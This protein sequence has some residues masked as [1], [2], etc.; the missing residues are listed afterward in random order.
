M[1][2]QQVTKLVMKDADLAPVPG[3]MSV[4]MYVPWSA[5]VQSAVF[6]VHMPALQAS[7]V[8]SKLA[9]TLCVLAS[10]RNL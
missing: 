7:V 1:W 6:F 5:N 3:F 4:Y 2:L 10:C 9:D 8:T